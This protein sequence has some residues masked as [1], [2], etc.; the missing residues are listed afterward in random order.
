MQ[1]CIYA[2]VVPPQLFGRVNVRI[3][4]GNTMT[5]SDIAM[6]MPFQSLVCYLATYYDRECY[7]STASH[8][9]PLSIRLRQYCHQCAENCDD[10]LN[11]V[12]WDV[13]G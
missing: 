6:T 2:T 11:F 12:K 13:S 4:S 9:E 5:L 10:Y 7:S 8:T 3:L 1:E